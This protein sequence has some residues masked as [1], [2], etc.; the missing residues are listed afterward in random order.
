MYEKNQPHKVALDTFDTYIHSG[1]FNG[2]KK[3][4]QRCLTLPHKYVQY[5]HKMSDTVTFGQ[6]YPT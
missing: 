6:V 4:T 1:K 3:Y 2:C 5:T